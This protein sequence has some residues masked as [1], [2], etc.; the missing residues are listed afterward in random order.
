M[1]C[2][3]EETPQEIAQRQEEEKR[4]LTQPYINKL[5]KLTRL[6][7][8]AMH[9]LDHNAHFTLMDPATEQHPEREVPPVVLSDE[10]RGWWLNHQ[11]EDRKRNTEEVRANALKKLTPEERKAL[12][13]K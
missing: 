5:D 8:E 12:G 4:R 11:A 13:L 6:L 1:P 7:C 10:L 3:Y 2:R 9:A